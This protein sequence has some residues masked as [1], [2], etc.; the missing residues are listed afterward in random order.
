MLD[1]PHRDEELL[2]A[3]E[4]DPNWAVVEPHDQQLLDIVQDPLGVCDQIRQ[5]FWI[6]LEEHPQRSVHGGQRKLAC[7]SVVGSGLCGIHAWFP[8]KRA[9]GWIDCLVGPILNEFW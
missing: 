7:R 6:V 4:L 5:K 3:T 2:L 8:G 1:L 9:D